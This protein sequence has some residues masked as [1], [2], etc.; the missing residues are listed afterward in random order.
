MPLDIDHI[1]KTTTLGCGEVLT[2]SGDHCD[3]N[4]LCETC[5]QTLSLCI[6]VEH[7]RNQCIVLREA[8]DQS[9]LEPLL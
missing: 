9:T 7:Y 1:M 8:L 4:Q 2:T 5:Q 3:E 6:E